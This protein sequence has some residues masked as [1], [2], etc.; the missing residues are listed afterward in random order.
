MHHTSYSGLSCKSPPALENESVVSVLYGE[1]S[2]AT[3]KTGRCF[4]YGCTSLLM[5]RSE[6]RRLWDAC[7]GVDLKKKCVVVFGY[8]HWPVPSALIIM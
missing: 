5:F 4:L 1:Y 6:G 8:K 3:V 2:F 7:P